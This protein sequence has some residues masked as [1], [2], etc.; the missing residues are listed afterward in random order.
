[1]AD[2]S[3][4]MLNELIK[5]I[6][7]TTEFVHQIS[8][9]NIEQVKAIEQV[10]ISLNEL[11]NI[12]QQNVASSEELSVSTNELKKQASSLVE[13]ISFSKFIIHNNNNNQ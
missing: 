4:I 1:M 10:Y 6:V 5:Q 9:S 8:S 2:N 7:Q 3:K 12:I 13:S 11:T